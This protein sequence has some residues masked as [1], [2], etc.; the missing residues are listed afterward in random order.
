MKDCVLCSIPQKEK[1]RTIKENETAFSCVNIEPLSESHVM[2]LPKE[3]KTNL[4]DLTEKE[5]K[6]ILILIEEVSQIL[7]K[8]FKTKGSI[9]VKNN[10]KHGTQEHIHFH[11]IATKNGLREII[12]PYLNVPF[13]KKLDVN[14]LNKL[15]AKIKENF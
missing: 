10:G 14:E 5:A 1:Y 15:A 2:I 9:V 6:D 12:A 4:K 3:H 11:I 7:E 13:R 8:K